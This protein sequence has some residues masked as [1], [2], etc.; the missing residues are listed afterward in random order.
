MCHT[1]EKPSTFNVCSTGPAQTSQ[2]QTHQT[3]HTT[4]KPYMCQVC[5]KGFKSV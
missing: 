4:E 1:E 3:T 2:L 5:S